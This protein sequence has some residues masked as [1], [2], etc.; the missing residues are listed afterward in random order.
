NPV[1]LGNPKTAHGQKKENSGVGNELGQVFCAEIFLQHFA[2]APAR[3][4]GHG[5]EVL[6][7]QRNR[8]FPAFDQVRMGDFGQYITA[9]HQGQVAA[10]LN[11]VNP[12]VGT[13]V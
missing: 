12:L 9:D 11:I 13:I 6:E 7:G 3:Q 5:V 8:G 1:C 2:Q 10:E 4:G